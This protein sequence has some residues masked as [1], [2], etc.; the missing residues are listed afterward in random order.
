M[1]VF[2]VKNFGWNN[3]YLIYK[4]RQL[5]EVREFLLEDFY[6]IKNINIFNI[7]YILCVFFFFKMSEFI[8]NS[9]YI[10]Y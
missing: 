7:K 10:L 8:L 2:S 3:I 4:I 5:V 6:F 9:I 1:Y